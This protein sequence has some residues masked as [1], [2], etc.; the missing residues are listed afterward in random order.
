MIN[1][2][3]LRS[4]LGQRDSAR[5]RQL[6]IQASEYW[7]D[8]E[9]G[10]TGPGE[11]DVDVVFPVYFVKP[12]VLGGTGYLEEGVSLVTGEYPSIT[13]MPA[14]FTYDEMPG[15]TRIYTG[16]RLSIVYSGTDG[17]PA[18][19]QWWARGI[20]LVNPARSTIQTIL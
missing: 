20:A 14:S 7:V 3:S 1:N 4:A 6:E 12:P 2:N 13:V 17:A 15:G 11:A 9:I 16:A 19:C 8:G 18:V 5:D 10:L